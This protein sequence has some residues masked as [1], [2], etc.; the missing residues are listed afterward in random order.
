MNTNAVFQRE[1][2]PIERLL[3][4][5]ADGKQCV[6]IPIEGAQWPLVCNMEELE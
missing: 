6:C 5:S 3:W 2:E 4:Q 1:N